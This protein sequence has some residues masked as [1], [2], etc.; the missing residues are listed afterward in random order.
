MHYQATIPLLTFYQAYASIVL[1]NT[2]TNTMHLIE[3]TY[4]I[5]LV[6]SIALHAIPYLIANLAWITFYAIM[7]TLIVKYRK[8]PIIKTVSADS[9]D[10]QVSI[11]S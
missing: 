11:D 10:D 9:S 5:A 3:I 6:Y 8:Q 4:L 2:K 7:L 1:G